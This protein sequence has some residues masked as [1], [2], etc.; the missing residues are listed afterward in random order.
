MTANPS[1]VTSDD[2]LWSLLA[3]IFT[4][5]V[6]IIIL[7]MEEK[8]RRPFIR[9]NNAHA[10]AL[11]VVNLVLGSLLFWIC[12]PLIIWVIGVYFGYKAYQGEYVKIPVITD[13]LAKQNWL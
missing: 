12:G 10:L 8:K 1:E 11:G 13:F 3:Y 7:L 5:L 4:P 9:Y 6:P 2:K